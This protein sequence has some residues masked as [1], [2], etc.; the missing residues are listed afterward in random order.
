MVQHQHKGKSWWCL[1]GGAIEEGETPEQAALRELREECHL[2]GRI[3]RETSRCYHTAGET[4][5]TFL[6][7]I[8]HQTPKRGFDPELQQHDQVLIAIRWMALSEIPERDRA[9]LWEAGLLTV[10]EFSNQVAGWGDE[11]SLPRQGD[12]LQMDEPT[13]PAG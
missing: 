7:D 8:G 3:L 5:Y 13:P 1:P 6:V 2:D 4:S 12:D 10:V 9:F 11:I